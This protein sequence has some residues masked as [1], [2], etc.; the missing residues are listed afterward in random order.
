[1]TTEIAI[2][3]KF[4]VALAADSAVT[5]GIGEGKVFTSFNK[6]F[7]LSRHVPVG[8]MVYQNAEFMGVPWE[9]MIDVYR[10]RVLVERKLDTL[11]EYAQDFIAFLENANRTFPNLILPEDQESFFGALIAVPLTQVRD[12]TIIGIEHA[13]SQE[14]CLDHTRVR[15][16]ASTA[17]NFVA[18]YHAN[19]FCTDAKYRPEVNDFVQ[20]LR[21]RYGPAMTSSRAATLEQLPFTKKASGA[22]DDLMMDWMGTQVLH[23]ETFCDNS[24]GYSGLVIAGFGENDRFPSLKAYKIAGI[25]GD[26]LLIAE[27][28]SDSGDSVSI[29]AN[30]PGKIVSFADNEMIETFLR[31]IAPDYQESILAAFEEQVDAMCSEI[32]TQF[33]GQTSKRRERLVGLLESKKTQITESFADRVW[34]ADIRRVLSFDEVAAVLP[35]DAL[36]DM[37]ETLVSLSS[38][39]KK[40]SEDKETVGGPTDV[41][42]ISR[43]EGFTWVKRSS[44]SCLG[45][46][47]HLQ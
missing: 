32:V 46:D 41:A 7:P 30:T 2:L 8:V 45:P 16:I 22:V 5:T 37:A 21:K 11:A 13:I 35:R 17:A 1:M 12:I 43:S 47:V 36:A 23:P 3:N 42:V 10:K 28:S 26:R 34:A 33:C 25:V 29:D 38:F 14:A 20:S 6:L 27:D 31:G 24:P 9:T 19:E 44:V 15:R 18:D 40:V 4:A 39:E